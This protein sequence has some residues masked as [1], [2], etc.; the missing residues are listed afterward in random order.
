MPSTSPRG[1]NGF[2]KCGM[3]TSWPA[4]RRRRRNCCEPGYRTTGGRR[5][6]RLTTP[7]ADPGTAP[8]ARFACLTTRFPFHFLPPAGIAVRSAYLPTCA[9]YRRTWV[10]GTDTLLARQLI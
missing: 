10:H 9:S 3:L 7:E 2:V 6:S 5:R 1:T 4:I 8:G